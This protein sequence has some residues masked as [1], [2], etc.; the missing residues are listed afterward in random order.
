ML[1]D[2]HHYVENRQA[3]DHAEKW[4]KKTGYH[5]DYWQSKQ[6]FLYSSEY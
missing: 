1:W 2:S 5:K 6:W 3:K 4:V